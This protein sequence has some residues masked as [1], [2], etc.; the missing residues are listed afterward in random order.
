VNQPLRVG[1]TVSDAIAEAARV[2]GP[3]VRGQ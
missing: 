1:Q 3:M 2:F